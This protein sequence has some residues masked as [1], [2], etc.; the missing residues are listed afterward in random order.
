MIVPNLFGNVLKVELAR[1]F[2]IL[3][4]ENEGI[5]LPALGVKDA[6]SSVLV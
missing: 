3:A 4:L 2:F 1:L 6:P 5:I